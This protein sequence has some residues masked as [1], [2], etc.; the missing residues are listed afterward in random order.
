MNVVSL[1][2]FFSGRLSFEKINVVITFD[3]GFKS[4]ISD[5]VPV[6]KELELPATFFISSGFVGLSEKDASEFMRSKLFLKPGP[7]RIMGGL[8][9]ADVRRIVEEGFT[10]GGHTLNHRNLAKLR[11]RDLLIHEIADDKMRL[12]KITGRKIEYFAYP[13]GAYHNPEINLSEM[14]IELGY[15]GAVTTEPG[16]NSVGS[17]PYLLRRELTGASMPG[18]VFGARVYGNYDAVWFLKQLVQRVIQWR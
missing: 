8:N 2:D 16:F 14:L 7:R 6:L 1:D 9:V 12:E 13:S 10:I 5:A 15:R 3:D 17:S 4:W 11:D 18:P